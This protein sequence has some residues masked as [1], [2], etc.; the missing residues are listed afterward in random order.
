MKAT[1]RLQL[2]LSALVLLLGLGSARAQTAPNDADPEIRPAHEDSDAKDPGVDKDDPNVRL[3]A[4]RAAWGV[5][6]PAFRQNA[7]KEGKSHS[8]KKNLAG[9]TWVNIGPTGA[10]YEQNGSFTGHV[11]DSGRARSILPHPTNPD[12]VYFLTSGGGLWRTK[13]WTAK[14]TQWQPLTDDLP[15]T[16]GGAAAFG[17]NASNIYLG[18]GDP[19]DQIL[20]GGSMVKSKNGGESWSPLIE[21]GNAVSVRDVKVDT[22]TNR[23]IVLVATDNGLFRSADEGETYSAVA[24]F[25]GMSVWSI[26]RTSAGWLVSAQPCNPAFVG[27]QCDG[28]TTLFLSKDRGATFA[29]ISNGGNVFSGNGRTTLAVAVPGENVVYAYSATAQTP[30]AIGDAQMKDVYRSS[31]GGQTWVANGVNS[32]KI[33]TNPVPGATNMPNM[34]ICHAQCWYNQMI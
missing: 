24:A 5:V 33:P 21:L 27:L 8:G 32:T 23:D 12:V 30:T 34:N 19:Y 10:D 13:N 22:S 11:R 31:D 26:E 25:A 17:K 16:G 1:R 2:L 3:E 28:A 20:V 15:T 9:R 29:P 6:T 14:D 7:L 4:Q 18:L